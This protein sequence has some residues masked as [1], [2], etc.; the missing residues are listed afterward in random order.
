MFPSDFVVTGPIAA[1]I[2]WKVRRRKKAQ[3]RV[4]EEIITFLIQLWLG[5]EPF[6]SIPVLLVVIQEQARIKIY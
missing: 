4:E 5:F 6:I 2:S 3:S 1:N